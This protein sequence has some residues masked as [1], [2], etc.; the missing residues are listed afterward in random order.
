MS[1]KATITEDSTG[2]TYTD[3]FIRVRGC[4]VNVSEG[5]LAVQIHYDIFY[6]QAAFVAGKLPVLQDRTYDVPRA[7]VKQNWVPA[8]K[9]RAYTEL[10]PLFPGGTEV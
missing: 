3:A 10:L 5:E 2:A 1:I 9:Q 8:I 7:S 4:T 6:D